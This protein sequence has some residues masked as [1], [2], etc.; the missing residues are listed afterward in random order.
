MVAVDA[1]AGSLSYSVDLRTGLSDS[2]V[3]P[4][5]VVVDPPAD[6]NRD[7]WYEIVLRI[8]LDDPKTSNRYNSVEF[9]IEY[10]A[11]PSGQV[12][13]NIGDSR[14]ND[15]GGGDASTQGNDAEVNIGNAEGDCRDLYV[16]GKDGTPNKGNLLERIPGFAARGVVAR[17]IVRDQQISWANHRGKC[18]KLSSPYLFALAGQ[19][20]TEGPVNHDIYAAFNRVIAGPRRFGSGVETGHRDPD[21][22][23]LPPGH[24][25]HRSQIT[26]RP[27]AGPGKPATSSAGTTGRAAAR[28]NA[29]PSLAAS[30]GRTSRPSANPDRFAC[31]RS[32]ITSSPP[33][34][35][36]ISSCSSPG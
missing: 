36:A 6:V 15:S 35:A 26:A 21:L 8:S 2:S 18:G 10:D 11:E 31:P 28:R 13:V 5:V 16:F 17:F 33:A 20:D 3:A 29:D 25:P 27:W 19:A 23:L 12:K 32:P 9:Q 34:P 24:W 7:G 1:R 30:P 22:D 14:T 4:H